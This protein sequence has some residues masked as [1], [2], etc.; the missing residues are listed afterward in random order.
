MLDYYFWQSKKE[1][2]ERGESI[3]Q[4]EKWVLDCIE[5]IG[6]WK[7]EFLSNLTKSYYSEKCP[8]KCA[9]CDFITSKGENLCFNK[10]VKK[11]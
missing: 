7:I 4:H 5:D 9:D 6:W 11:D 2:Y 3:T 1:Q 10:L 8:F